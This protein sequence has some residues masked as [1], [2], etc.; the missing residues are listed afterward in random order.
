MNIE[1]MKAV[2]RYNSALGRLYRGRN[3]AR[4]TPKFPG[5]PL[6]ISVGGKIYS[7]ARIC[8]AILH[9]YLP[10]TVRHHD[11]DVQNNRGDNL[12][13]P[14]RGKGCPPR[15]IV[16]HHEGKYFGVC[17]IKSRRTGNIRG[18]QGSIYIDN[19]RHR[20]AVVDTPELARDLRLFLKA[21]LD[22]YE[23]KKAEQK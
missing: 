8:F 11:E 22:W 6:Q 20:T 18:Y 5:G 12:Y 17:V 3:L 23:S 10:A 13:D 9:G 1:T 15:D 4:G 19:V 16:L 7:Y 2:F 21:E 14:A